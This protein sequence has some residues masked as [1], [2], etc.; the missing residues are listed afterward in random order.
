V[1]PSFSILSQ[2]DVVLA[3][4]SRARNGVAYA[5]R[6]GSTAPAYWVGRTARYSPDCRDFRLLVILLYVIGYALVDDSLSDSS[7]LGDAV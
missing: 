4:K 3:G 2:L 1:R 5:A 6:T 7:P